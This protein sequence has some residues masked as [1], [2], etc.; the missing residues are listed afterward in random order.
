MTERSSNIMSR[1]LEAHRSQISEE[2]K[3]IDVNLHK[4][5]MKLFEKL[6]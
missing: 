5:V 2:P 1:T 4:I 6:S 3:L